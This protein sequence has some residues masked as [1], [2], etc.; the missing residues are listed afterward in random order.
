MD[1]DALIAEASTILDAVAGP[2][3][4]DYRADSVVRKKGDG[5]ATEVDLA[6]ERWVVTALVEITGIGLHGEEFGGTAVYSSW[7]WVLDP[8][9]GTFNYMA[10]SPMGAMLLDLLNHGEP[11]EGLIWLLFIGERCT[12]IASIAL[13]KNFVLQLPLS[14]SEL[15]K[16]LVGIGTFN[17]DTR[18]RI[19]GRYRLTMVENLSRP[20]LQLRMPGSIGTEFSWIA[21]GILREEVSCGYHIWDNAEGFALVQTTGGVVID[22]VGESWVPASPFV[23]AATPGVYSKIIEIICSTGELEDYQDVLG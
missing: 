15:S 19:S 11:V 18:S 22:L 14:Y 4:V 12:A 9:D 23:V 17:V 5:F 16:A 2:F 10:G 3:L 7:V 13:M 21:N 20:G 1:L 6:I 8:I